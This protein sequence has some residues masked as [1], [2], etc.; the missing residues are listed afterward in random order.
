MRVKI[1]FNRYLILWFIIFS[2]IF[3][4]VVDQVFFSVE[5]PVTVTHLKKKVST[6][7]AVI[8]KITLTQNDKSYSRTTGKDACRK[9]FVNEQA[10]LVKTE[11]LEKWVHVKTKDTT[12]SEHSI[13]TTIALDWAYFIFSIALLFGSFFNLNKELKRM[14][15]V[16]FTL[17]L[18]KS[19]FM[20]NHAIQ[21]L[22]H[23]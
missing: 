11:L 5:H 10:T 12:L 16:V 14:Y 8:C 20:W 2:G 1:G 6:K 9:L 22:T 7:G 19:I 17:L 13:D 4:V 3:L 15:Y 23:L 18:I 21:N